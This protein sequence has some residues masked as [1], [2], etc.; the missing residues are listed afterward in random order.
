M[1]HS[2]RAAPV[3]AV[4][5]GPAAATGEEVA[6]DDPIANSEG[7]AIGVGADALAQRRDPAGALVSLVDRH[8]SPPLGR[9]ELPTPHV[10]VRPTDVGQADPDQRCPRLRL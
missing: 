6:E 10:Q 2:L 1:M 4:Q 5:T 9:V 7:L 3:L 8:G